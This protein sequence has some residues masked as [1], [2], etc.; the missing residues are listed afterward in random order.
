MEKNLTTDF[1]QNELE[2]CSFVKTILML[3]VVLYHSLLFW[4]GNW[5]SVEPAISA[6]ILAHVAAFFN[7]FHIHA[8][9]L[10]SGYLF[11]YLKFEKGKYQKFVPFI[12]NKA[13]RLL[14]PYLF[15]CIFW[16]I[17]ITTY[18]FKFEVGEIINRYLFGV[19]PSQLWFLLMLFVV[20]AIFHLLSDLFE[21]HDFAGLVFVLCLYA[22]SLVGNKFMPNYF[23]IWNACSFSIYFWIGLKL[24]QKGTDLVRK[25][26]LLIYVVIVVGLFI[27]S[28]FVLTGDHLIIKVLA[29]GVK[30][31]L[32][33]IGAVT[34]FLLL[35][36][37]ANL[38]SSWKTNRAFKVLT[39]FSMPMYLFHQQVIYFSLSLLN[40]L[41]TPYLHFAINFVVSCLVSI[42]LSAILMKFKW[43]RFLIGEK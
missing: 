16:V 20:F 38:F 32:H 35:Q 22:V 29:I 6:P 30:F 4:R 2:N 36:K 27:L 28:T 5:F 25:I 43:T 21:K 12:T 3:I 13:K 26:P 1:R 14:M 33:V 37:V 34:A 23:N 24:R 9:T 40:G 39:R 10:V 42:L 19:A 11:A 31:L 41:I 7:I 15:T 18:F 8:F 17:P